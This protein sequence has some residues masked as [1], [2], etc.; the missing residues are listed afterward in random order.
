MSSGHV[1][2]VRDRGWA[3]PEAQH[4]VTIRRPVSEVFAFLADGLNG[5]K[6]RTGVLALAHV[7]GMDHALMITRHRDRLA[8]LLTERLLEPT[9]S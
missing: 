6:W 3:M 5:P 9:G 1:G 4:Q 8:A 7:S 2:D